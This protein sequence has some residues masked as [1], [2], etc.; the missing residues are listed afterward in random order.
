MPTVLGAVCW[1]V[2]TSFTS[3]AA[4]SESRSRRTGRPE[5]RTVTGSTPATA[6]ADAITASRTSTTSGRGT[7]RSIAV[8]SRV[9]ATRRPAE[10]QR[11]PR[12]SA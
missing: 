6:S 7:P 9:C 8:R 1:E 4:L 5:A 2:M 3:T 10:R 12:R 11:S